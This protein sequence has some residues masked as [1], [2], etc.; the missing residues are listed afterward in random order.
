MFSAP[1]VDATSGKTLSQPE[2]VGAINGLLSA[3]E[4]RVMQKFDQHFNAHGSGISARQVLEAAGVEPVD[5]QAK[6][7]K[8]PLVAPV[9]EQTTPPVAAP[10]PV[11]PVTPAIPAEPPKPA[12]VPP[13]VTPEQAREFEESGGARGAPSPEMQQSVAAKGNEQEAARQAQRKAKN[14]AAIAAREARREKI[15]REASIA[16]DASTLARL[17]A[18]EAA[19]AATVE[20][21]KGEAGPRPQTKAIADNQKRLDGIRAKIKDLTK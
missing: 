19:V 4:T 2:L 7:G 16:D 18:D 10:P 13:P 12:Y 1:V 6:V 21:L 20:R 8:A 9:L 11:T 5:M 17:R 3:P 15:K 14:D